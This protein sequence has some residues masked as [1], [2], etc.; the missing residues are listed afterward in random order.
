LFEKSKV[1]IPPTPLIKE[2]IK[3][4]IKKMGDFKG[5]TAPKPKYGQ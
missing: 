4:G 3:G 1:L 2:G 5:A